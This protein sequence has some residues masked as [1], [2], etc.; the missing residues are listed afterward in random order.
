MASLIEM[1]RKMRPLI[2]KAAQSLAD[3]EAVQAPY[4]YDE[5]SGDSVQYVKDH[6][7]RRNGKVYKVIAAH[8]SQADWPPETANTLFTVIDEVHV[9]TLEDPIPY[10]GNMEIF[11]GKYYVQ[12]DVVYL[13]NRDSDTPLHHALKDLV[14]IYVEVIS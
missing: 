13:C 1:A 4:L 3:E 8:T 2:V 9:G 12:D 6:K 7:V 14:N 11:N 10:S 5:W